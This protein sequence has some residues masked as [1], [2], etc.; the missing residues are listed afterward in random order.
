M[1]LETGT[2]VSDLV[3]TNPAHADG[4]NNADAHLRL[5]KSTIKAT[6]PNI[7]GP[8]SLTQAQINGLLAGGLTFPDGTV[9][10]P[11]VTFGADGTTGFYRVG[12]GETGIAGQLVGNGACPPG[13]IVDFGMAAA[14]SGWLACDG[15]AI[16]RTTYAA[17]FAAIGTLWGAGDGTTTFNVPTLQYRFRRHRDASTISGNVGNLQTPANLAHT[18]GVSG[19]TAA[20]NAAHNHTFSGS[21]GAMSANASHTHSSNAAANIGGSS[22]GGGGFAINAPG[23]ATINATNTDH[24]HAF[25]GTTGS[26]SA[27]HAHGFSV[28][29]AGG[30]ADDTETRPYSATVLTCIKT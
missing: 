18:H 26:E 4:L 15:Q 25:S 13:A 2:Y 12:T 9:S 6:F 23:A 3:V 11:S 8:V 28:T 22:T 5:I 27:N 19:T 20:E 24:S 16:S 29:S 30:S 1:A 10:A 7:T 21:T 14:P 17:L